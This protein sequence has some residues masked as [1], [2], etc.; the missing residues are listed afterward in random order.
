MASE[1]IPV[2]EFGAPQALDRPLGKSIWRG[3]KCRCPNCGDGRLFRKFIKPV[4][5]CQHCGEDFRP[6]R[7]D[8]L[9]AYLVVMIIGHVMVGGYLGAELLFTLTSWEHLAIWVPVSVLGA[10]ALLQPVKGGVIGLQW[11]LR[12]HGFSGHDDE[13]EDVLPLSGKS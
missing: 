4:D 1:P 2:I 5:H 9:P 8:D 12:M 3:V 10:L 6:Q 13:P 11:A 7:A